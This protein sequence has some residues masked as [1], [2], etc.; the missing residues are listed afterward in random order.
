MTCTAQC[1]VNFGFEPSARDGAQSMSLRPDISLTGRL[2]RTGG[3]DYMLA[4]KEMGD[5]KF[6]IREDQLEA[7]KSGRSIQVD[8]GDGIL[9]TVEPGHY[10]P[11]P[12][13]RSQGLL[14]SEPDAVDD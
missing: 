5:D 10:A 9:V 7:L 3:W 8:F 4:S 14:F 6:A 2:L 12:D 11:A 1:I 13:A